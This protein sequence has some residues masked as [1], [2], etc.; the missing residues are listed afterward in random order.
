MQCMLGHIRHGQKIASSDLV[1]FSFVMGMEKAQL[2][3]H[4]APPLHVQVMDSCGS[5]PQRHSH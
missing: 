1:Y 3:P 4:K 2:E 5:H